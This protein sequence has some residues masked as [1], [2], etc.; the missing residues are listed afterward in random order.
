MSHLPD[1]PDQG[2]VSPDG[3]PDRRDEQSASGRSARSGGPEAETRTR[4]EC[5]DALRAADATQQSGTARRIAAEEQEASDK[6]NEKVTESRWMWTEYQRKW[7]PSERPSTDKPAD[8]SLEPADNARVEAACDRIAHREREKITPAMQ[9]VESKDPD[10]HLVGLGNCLKDRD[11]IK[12]K[13]YRS[14]KN[15]GRSP[16]QAVSHVPD[17]IRY[18]FQYRESRYT[19]GVWADIGRLKE[20]GFELHKLKNSWSKEQYK[21]VNSQWIDPDTGQRFEVQFHTRISFEAK[22]LTHDAYKRLRT[23]QPDKFEQ[24]VLEAFQKKVAADVS[25]PP[26]ATDIPNYPQGGA[27]AR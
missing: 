8:R 1:N 17:T 9:V 18:T 23:H 6:W 4:Q 22:Q 11:R 20:Q 24:M 19:Q 27:D 13:I 2:D 12:E 16:E 7:P 21:G 14:V 26:G 5:Y 3:Q 15:F 25:V 10:R